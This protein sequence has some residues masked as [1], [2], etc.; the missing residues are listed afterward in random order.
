MVATLISR[1]KTTKGATPPL[2]PTQKVPAGAAKAG[3]GWFGRGS[4]APTPRASADSPA[5]AAEPT[6]AAP[7]VAQLKPTDAQAAI[8]PTDVVLATEGKSEG[9]FEAIVVKTK[10]D[11]QLVLK[12]RDWEDEPEFARLRTEVAFLPLGFDDSKGHKRA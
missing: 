12:W 3:R 5:P 6:S 2:K 1:G 10:G 4:S 8:K 7:V 9:W 11:A